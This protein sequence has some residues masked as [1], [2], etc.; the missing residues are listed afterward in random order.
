MALLK[1]DAFRQR[2]ITSTARTRRRPWFVTLLAVVS[3][4]FSG[5]GALDDLSSAKYYVLSPANSDGCRVAVREVSFLLAGRGTVYVVGAAG[6][7][8][9]VSSWTADD[10]YKPFSSG[11]YELMWYSDGGS[12]ILHSNGDPVWPAL[13]EINC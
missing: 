4:A 12:L 3:V 8:R 11:N 13:H 5:L 6:V 2:S 10:G 1:V 7:G 9:E